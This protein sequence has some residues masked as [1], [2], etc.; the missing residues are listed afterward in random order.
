MQINN[1]L[2]DKTSNIAV[3]NRYNNM[4]NKYHVFSKQVRLFLNINTTIINIT[5]N[6]GIYEFL[7]SIYSFAIVGA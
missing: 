2:E 4:H 6:V 5:F 7:K 1:Q 3:E